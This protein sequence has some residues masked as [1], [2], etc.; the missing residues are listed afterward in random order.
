GY[1][2]SREHMLVDTR[3]YL[4]KEW[5]TDAVVQLE[6]KLK[7]GRDFK[8]GQRAYA[9]ARC[10]VCHRFGGE[11]GATGPDLSQVAGRFGLKELAESIV[12]PSKVISDQYKAS[13]I[14]TKADK[15]VT[16]KIVNDANGVYTV[17]VDPEDSTKVLELK[18]EDVAEVKSSNISLMPAKLIDTLNENEVLD[19]LA[20]MLSRGDP[21]H[22]MF[23]APPKK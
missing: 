4:P 12:E 3:L 19:M 23:K 1:V 8:A 10:V 11:G 22:P 20:Y 7:S 2:S 9:A 6:E 16:G 14:V 5:T 18:K 13:I 15:T 21:N 17:V